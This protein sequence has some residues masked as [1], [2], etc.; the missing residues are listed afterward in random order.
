MKQGTQIAYV[1]E[2][3]NG[4]LSHPDVE[5]GFVMSKRGNA[6]FCRYWVKG[7]PGELRT[8]ANSELTPSEL[9][10]ED[11]S[12]PQTYVKIALL[13]IEIHDLIHEASQAL[14]ECCHV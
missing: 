12:V 2:H 14:L 8:V 13:E 6:H 9:L 3:A 4:D 11:I 10:V 5:F 1:P 7:V